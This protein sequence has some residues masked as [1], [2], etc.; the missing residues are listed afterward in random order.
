MRF[1]VQYSKFRD[2][3][4]YSTGIYK[5]HNYRNNTGY[6]LNGRIQTSFLDL[7]L[8]GDGNALNKLKF[9]IVDIIAFEGGAGYLK[10]EVDL[11]DPVAVFKVNQ[12]TLWHNVGL[13]AGFAF[14]VR[15]IPT[16]DVGVKYGYLSHLNA[17]FGKTS[18]IPMGNGEIVTAGRSSPAY[19]NGSNWG[20]LGRYRRIYGELNLIRDQQNRDLR[21]LSIFDLKYRFAEHTT[22]ASYIGLQFGTGTVNSS[23]PYINL[24]DKVSRQWI[25][26]SIGKMTNF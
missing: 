6:G 7:L 12:K 8:F 9:R 22:W 4:D 20:F 5:Y 1:G 17:T 3:S 18:Y 2:N 10:D 21:I 11:Y 14:M 16:V 24:T 26:L 19:G 13:E 25:Q 23:D 15:V